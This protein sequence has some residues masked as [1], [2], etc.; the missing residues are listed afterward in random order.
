MTVLHDLLPASLAMA[1]KK[2]E[3]IYNFTNPG[4][5]S[6]N[7]IL[8]LYK[9]HVDPTYTWSNFTVRG[10]AGGGCEG[11]SRQAFACL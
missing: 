6:H 11:P 7:E 2:L 3:G 10:C 4:A 9:K 8:A 1:A 5:I